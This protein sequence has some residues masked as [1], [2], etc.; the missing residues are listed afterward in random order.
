MMNKNEFFSKYKALG[1]LLA[2]DFHDGIGGDT[3]LAI[4]ERILTEL[5]SSHE[6]L[7]SLVKDCERLIQN[8]GSEWGIL[9]DTANRHFGNEEEARAWLVGIFAVWDAALR[10]IDGAKPS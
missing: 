4:A 6:D 2:G 1:G 3:D 7:R 10:K 5:N 9:G 8:I